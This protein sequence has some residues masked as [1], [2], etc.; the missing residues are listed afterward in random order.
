MILFSIG[1]RIRLL[2]ICLTALVTLLF[3]GIGWIIL[4]DAE[5]ALHDAYF[6]A[7]AK[8]VAE[9]GSPGL[10]PVGVSAHPDADFL[11]SKMN[12]RDIPTEP[13][14][15][16]IFANDDLTQSL[17]VRGLSDRLRL[18]F[19][20][21]Y[22]REYRL[23]IGSGVAAGSPRFVLAD[24]STQE[25]SEGATDS[26]IHK[27]IFLS[28]GL[29]LI[30]LG[31]SEL[32][33]RWTLKP[34]RRLTGLVIRE[35]AA[36]TGARFHADFP[37][38]EIGQLAAALDDYRSRLEEMVSRERRFLAD[39][40]HELRTPI[41][42]LTTALDILGTPA[43]KGTNQDQVRERLRRSAHRMERLVR[44]FLLLARDKTPTVDPEAID[45]GELV[46]GVA[47]EIRALNPRSSLVVS[48]VCPSPIIV[49]INSEA[50]S[51]LCHNLIGNAYLHVGDGRLEIAA[52]RHDQSTSIV[53]TDDGPGL[54]ENPSSYAR[55][56]NGI[57]L[58]LVERVCKACG[59]SFLKGSSSEGGARLEI[60]IPA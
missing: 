50:L 15:Y 58:T 10:L 55:G 11:R 3:A 2:V 13:G 53:F 35:D 52:R 44:T 49:R 38:D 19:I 12:L 20:L 1:T 8:G 31:V 4:L 5:D 45:V 26:A 9:G 51:I 36:T 39:C 41:A 54:P 59:W 60:I 56:G 42:T 27:L 46:Q 24:L 6:V 22:E 29:F 30:A 47:D 48:L 34:L 25:V 33:T 18:W 43:G 7:A 23:W 40:S 37:K 28:A 17:L 32:I 16:E 57:G 21:G 14:T